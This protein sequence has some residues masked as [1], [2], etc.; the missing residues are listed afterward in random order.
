MFQTK[1]YGK[2][3]HTFC[4]QERFFVEN[5]DVYEIMWENIGEPG[6]PQMTIWR[7]RIASWIPK[8]TNTHS[9]HVKLTDLPL[10][11]LLH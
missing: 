5:L 3:K 7:M 9:E 4:V 2:S 8:A 1:L 6:R 10:Q 11:L